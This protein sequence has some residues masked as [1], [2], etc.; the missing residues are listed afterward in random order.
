MDCDAPSPIMPIARPASGHF[1]VV[2]DIDSGL[3]DI[4]V[5]SREIT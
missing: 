3:S 4:D 2:A 1:P 5:H